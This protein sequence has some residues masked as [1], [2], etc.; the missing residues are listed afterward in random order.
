MHALQIPPQRMP[1]PQYNTGIQN[2]TGMHYPVPQANIPY[3]SQGYGNQP[4]FLPNQVTSNQRPPSAPGQAPAKHARNILK[5]EDP[6]TGKDMTE[7]IL[8]I[9]HSAET[10][11]A[12][13]RS[14]STPLANTE[15][16]VQYSIRM[17]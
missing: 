8:K 16:C 11:V 7:E 6:N 5:I 1:N 2:Q 9:T 17:L 10:S 4:L 12:D 15:V 3:S 13:A 14:R